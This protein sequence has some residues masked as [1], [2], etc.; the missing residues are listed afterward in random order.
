MGTDS[1]SKDE[2]KPGRPTLL[3]MIL[4][5]L[6]QAAYPDNTSIDYLYDAVGNRR[7]MTGNIQRIWITLMPDT[8]YDYEDRLTSVTDAEK[9][10]NYIYDGDGN[11]IGKTITTGTTTETYD[12]I[13]D[14]SAGLP[15]VLVEK[16]NGTEIFDY[17]YLGRLY[18]RKGSKGTIYYHQDG[19]GSILA[20]T[21]ASGNVLNKYA[22]DAFGTTKS[23][24]DCGK[25]Y[26]LYRRTV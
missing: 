5:Q 20:I 14:Y 17:F 11:L 15:R 13:H 3:M 1:A 25:Q 26:P 21:D 24:R 22:Y 19:L 12:Y 16:K 4:N 10:I 18:A 7:T 23:S 2:T 6:I 9:T 8:N